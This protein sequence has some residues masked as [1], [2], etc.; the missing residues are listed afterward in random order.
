MGGCEYLVLGMRNYLE[1]SLIGTTVERRV[2]CWSLMTLL[3]G[4]F[5]SMDVG[6]MYYWA[7]DTLQWEQL[8]IG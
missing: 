8:S 2:I 3:E 4:S 7:P 5:P 6:E 1:I